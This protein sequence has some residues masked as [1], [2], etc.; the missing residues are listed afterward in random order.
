MDQ[1]DSPGLPL[2]ADVMIVGWVSISC[3]TPVYNA[4]VMSASG[5][6]MRLLDPTWT[7]SVV[8][9]FVDQFAAQMCSSKLGLSAELGILRN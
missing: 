9:D 6:T 3:E 2:I 5:F 4:G 7:T 1:N 8:A